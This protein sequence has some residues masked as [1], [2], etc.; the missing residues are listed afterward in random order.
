MQEGRVDLAKAR[1][2]S[3]RYAVYIE[4]AQINEET[5]VKAGEFKAKYDISIADAFIAATAYLKSSIVISD[6]PDFKK[7]KEIEAL[8][9]E[10]FAKK[11]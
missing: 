10:E 9:E 3:L 5:A 7:I 8:S 4:K 11:L 6:D 1:I 2:E